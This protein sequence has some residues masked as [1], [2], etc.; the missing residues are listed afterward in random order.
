MNAPEH[1]LPD[2]AVEKITEDEKALLVANNGP[3]AGYSGAFVR[4]QAVVPQPD[5][6]TYANMVA[7]L[8]HLV[9]NDFL[10]LCVRNRD[11]LH[12][13][14]VHK[15]SIAIMQVMTGRVFP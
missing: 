12:V 11:P 4:V 2:W 3:A 8:P 14:T 10:V 15:D 9:G 7:K 1:D 13:L 5:A 6:Q